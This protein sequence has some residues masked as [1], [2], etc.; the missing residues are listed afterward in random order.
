MLMG[1]LFYLDKSVHLLT[2]LVIKQKKTMK[3]VRFISLAVLLMTATLLHAQSFAFKVLASKGSTEVKS[4][5]AWEPL[6]VGAQLKAA[7]E[8]KIPANGYLGLM[9][10]SGKPLQ[11]KEPGS[12]KVV[13]LASQVGKGSSALNKYT[14]FILSSNQ[15]KQNK[16]A[17]TG[18]V[19][20][21]VKKDIMLCLPSDPSKAEVAGDR[22]LALW[23]SDGSPNYK[24][25]V[26]DLGEDVLATYEV[27]EPFVVIEFKDKLAGAPQI[28]VQVTSAEGNVSEKYTVKRLTGHKKNK[29]IGD[30]EELLQSTQPTGIDKFVQASYFESHLMIVDALT[31]YKDAAALEPDV[32]QEEYER[33]LVRFGFKKE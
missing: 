6:K 4:G 15:E 2:L 18:A 20:R 5:E 7:D 1:Q 23:T 27:T 29:I 25:V 14:D 24:V 3:T 9:H 16:L 28:L 11:V 21:G 12:H 8:I 31:A 32:Y 30:V 33:F 26:M 13:D 19:H 22:F 17:A 10:A